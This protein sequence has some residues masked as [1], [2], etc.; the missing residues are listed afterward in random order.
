MFCLLYVACVYCI[1]VGAEPQDFNPT[2][3][4]IT[5]TADEGVPGATQGQNI[6]V[7]IPI[8]DDERDEPDEEVFAASLSIT[9]VSNTVRPGALEIARNVCLCRIAD[10]DRKLIDFAVFLL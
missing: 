8:I 6:S 9:N 2:M 1:F 7:P 4:N 5:F 3:L 10:D